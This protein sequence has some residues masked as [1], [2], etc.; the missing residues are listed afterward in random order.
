[1]LHGKFAGLLTGA[2]VA[3]VILSAGPQVRGQS[4]EPP[5]PEDGEKKTDPN[6]IRN[7]IGNLSLVRGMKKAQQE[8]K[9]GL[10]SKLVDQPYYT[11]EVR[12]EKLLFFGQYP[13]A[14]AHYRE[15]L[16]KD[17]Q[18]QKFIEG[19]LEA[20]LRQGRMKDLSR[21]DE[22]VNALTE[23]QRSTPRVIRLRAEALLQRGRNGE[24]RDLLKRFVES[25]TKLEP[26]DAEVVT[27]YTTY[28]RALE[29]DAEYSAAAAVYGKLLPL[30]EGNFPE[31]PAI[32][33]Q[34]ALALE[35]ASILTG[36]G[37]EKHRT[38][39]YELGQIEQK[40]QTY[41]PAKLVE[42]EILLASHNMKEGAQ[43][44]QE[45]LD[46]NPNAQR[47]RLLAVE[48][49][50]QQYNFEGAREQLDQIAA[51]SDRADVDAYEGRLLLKE[52]LPE[53]AI[54]PLKEAIAKNPRHAR[55]HGWLAAAYYLLADNKRM[56]EQLDAMQ[57]AGGAPGEIH[58]VT[59]YEAAEVL[60]DARQFT[61]A[62]KLYLQAENRAGWWSEPPAA[63]AQLYLETGQEAKAKASYDKSFAIDPYNMRAYNQLIL[64]NYLQKFS[65][66]E[67]KTRLR[68]GSNLPAFIIKYEPQDEVL[69]HLAMEW[70]EKVRPELWSYFQIQDLPAPTQIEMF[71]SHEQFGVRTTGLPWIGTVGACTGNVIAMDV[72]RAATGEGGAQVMGNFDWARVL[73]HEYTHTVTLALTNNR[74]P[75]WLT[76]AAACNQEQAPRD[77]ENC[78]LLASNFRAGT[79]FKIADLNWGFIRPKRSIDRQLAY[80]ESQWLYEYLVATYGL[81]KMLDFMHAFRDGLYEAQAWEKA[82]GKSMSEMDTEFQAWAKAQIDSWGLPTDPLPKRA[83]VDAALAKNPKDVEALVKLGW[84]LAS[85]GKRAD[86]QAAL[87]KAVA[88]DPH[89]VRAR[90]LLGA[91]LIPKKTDR[92]RTILEGVIK[93]DPHRPVALRTLGIIAMGAHD[94]D[95]AEKWF[96]QLQAERPLEETS[97]LNLAGIYLL[98]KD[99]KEA[100][101]QLLE[102]QRHEQKDE[103]I[104][105]KLAELFRAEH[106]LPEAEQSAYR[107]IRIDPYNAINHELMA[108]VLMEEKQPGRAV[109]F[110]KDATD[111]QPKIP[112]FW[113]GL[114]NAAGE[115]GDAATAAAAAKKAVALQ[116]SSPAK[117]WLQSGD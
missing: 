91:V 73:R 113:E 18:N 43:A 48:F 55:A 4:D 26:L 87:E 78:Q 29:E 68:P 57:T 84:L 67:S 47:A 39:L 50:I 65:T 93:D 76:E 114:A 95:A 16:K 52:R 110:W 79:L 116:P 106:Q 41:W 56:Q 70:M 94:Y 8:A 112:E 31:D 102:L 64:L 32:A 89:H 6:D 92:A 51:H 30:A 103:R 38:V 15:L 7:A 104:P 71:P 54:A 96:T 100:I 21:F 85:G 108:E 25:H 80:M 58:P 59:L 105:R 69:A 109:E 90:E 34:L 45:V 81:P 107:A 101:G 33:T 46:L 74:I 9:E 62:E 72:P 14:E 19:R 5:K 20:V 1:M 61:A 40:D 86:A 60:R 36:V 22:L 27:N 37:R 3:A 82:Y 10:W 115:S 53:K 2:V 23:P 111:L 97:Y 35:R 63:L 13:E 99:N 117:K 66:L 88:I 24:A 77:W 98:K 49:A 12:A 75:H 11:P 17:P 44:I 42:A 83:E 28:A